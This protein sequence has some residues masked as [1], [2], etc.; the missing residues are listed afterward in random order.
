MIARLLLLFFI[1][2]S[3]FAFAQNSP[4]TSV[5]S[6]ISLNNE[7]VNLTRFDMS[8]FID[9]TGKMTLSQIQNQTFTASKNELTLGTNAKTT[10]SKITV[11]NLKIC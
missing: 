10:W 6:V 7:Q 9:K 5:D 3:F 11:K 4:T 2:H 8:Y 1:S